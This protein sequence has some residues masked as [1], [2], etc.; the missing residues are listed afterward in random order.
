[1][2]QAVWDLQ[3]MS[4]EYLYNVSENVSFLEMMNGFFF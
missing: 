3:A 2:V 1:M 4:S